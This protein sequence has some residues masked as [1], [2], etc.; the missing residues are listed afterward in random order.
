MKI[1][2]FRCIRNKKL[3]KVIRIEETCSFPF[4]KNFSKCSVIHDVTREIVKRERIEP[5]KFY[6]GSLHFCG[7]YCRDDKHETL[8]KHFE[9]FFLFAFHA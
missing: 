5:F 3:D 4:G 1:L 6:R 2:R 8:S 9:H 7:N